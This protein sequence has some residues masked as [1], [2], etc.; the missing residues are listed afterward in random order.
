MIHRL[1]GRLLGPGIA[2]VA[3]AGVFALGC[4]QRATAPTDPLASGSVDLIGQAL[5]MA[6]PN[7]NDNASDCAPLVAFELNNFS[8]STVV[9]NRFYPLVPGTKFVYDGYADRGGGVL[10][11]R[12]VFIVTD[13]VKEIDGA[14][15]VVL[16]DRDFSDGQLVE[17]ELSFQAQDND[18]NVWTLGEY[19]E[20][21]DGGVFTGAPNT[22][23][24]GLAGAHGGILLEAAA[25]VRTGDKFLQGVAPDIA[26][27]DCAKI[28]K[29]G[30]STCGPTGC[31]DGVLVVS[32]R[33]PL[34]PGTG[35]QLKYY[36][37]G[38][39]N[40]QIG[41]VGDKEKETLVLVEKV[42]LGAQEL[43]EAREAALA[44][45]RHAYQV[46]P[47]YQYTPPAH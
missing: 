12:V 33:S 41:A 19:P 7:S 22:W 35:R 20:E 32:E 6:E 13:L 4:G 18:G 26:F 30:E 17:A 43:S 34:E 31:Y 29:V 37:P 9:D 3:L 42:R 8:H 27:L 39:G 25:A 15:S 36:A 11:H 1:A 28:F 23:I 14:K 40:V 24:S 2:L 44:L 47:D 16:W 46:V 45:D 21:Y 5:R 10:P 38:V